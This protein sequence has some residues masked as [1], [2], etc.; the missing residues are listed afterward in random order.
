MKK[1]F[2]CIS[3]MIIILFSGGMITSYA[4][5]QEVFHPGSNTE[6]FYLLGRQWGLEKIQIERAWEIT[7]GKKEIKV[8]VIDSGIDVTHGD[9]NNC[10]DR[11]LSKSFLDEDEYFEGKDG[12]GDP[13]PRYDDPLYDIS[14]HGTHIAG[15]IAAD[16]NNSYG[17]VGVAPNVTLVSLRVAN[18]NE[19]FD[20][21]DV[22][23]AINYAEEVGID[24]LNYSA[25]GQYHKEIAEAINN[26]SGL[27]VC[28]AGN[29]AQNN[30]QKG[31]YPSNLKLPNL[32]S[33]GATDENDD[34][35]QSEKS[36]S[37]SNYG[38]KNVDLFAPGAEII[39]TYPIMICN[40][41]YR[42]PFLDKFHNDDHVE[43]GFHDFSGTSMATPYVTAVAA[44]LLSS[45]YSY[46]PENLKQIIMNSVDKMDKLKNFCVSGGRLNAA[47]ALGNTA[48]K[49]YFKS[50]YINE[51][52]HQNLCSCGLSSGNPEGHYVLRAVYEKN[53]IYATC[54]G[55]HTKLDFRKDFASVIF[56]IRNSKKVTTNGSYILPSGVV[57]LVEEDLASYLDGTLIFYDENI[58]Y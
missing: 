4:N 28:A 37:G 14:G 39:S 18:I 11:E 25:G 54:L 57:V 40:G 15:I 8:G 29:N 3:L 10:V 7:V 19:H 30:D 31:H 5:F 20:P 36:S 58:I 55:C 13:V 32:I 9:L 21:D 41:T 50:R 43:E 6:P 23:E 46:T 1:K 33:V 47:K 52:Q 45:D 34:L 48:H 22:K 53:P 16:S 2:F 12:N 17:M 38:A 44:L 42:T 35:W 51:R 56:S 27:F 26:Y 24:I 49:H